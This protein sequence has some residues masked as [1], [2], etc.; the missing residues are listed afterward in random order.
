MFR[1]KNYFHTETSRNRYFINH[2]RSQ[3]KDCKIFKTLKI[4]HLVTQ[5]LS[6]TIEIAQ[7]AKMDCPTRAIC[8]AVSEAWF[9]D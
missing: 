7:K 5:S 2:Q 9:T 4:I 1:I 6:G 8:K 3:R